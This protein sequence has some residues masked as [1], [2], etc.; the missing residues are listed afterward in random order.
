MEKAR[1][2]TKNKVRN[3][4]L[5]YKAI[6]LLYMRRDLPEKKYILIKKNIME[7]NLN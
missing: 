6:R 2:E 7:W 4:P 3:D 5:T 1:V